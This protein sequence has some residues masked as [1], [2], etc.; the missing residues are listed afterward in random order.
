M[1]VRYRQLSATLVAMN[2]GTGLRR[3]AVAGPAHLR[4]R[5]Q[6]IALLESSAVFNLAAPVLGT[7][8][9]GATS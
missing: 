4:N 5:P 7:A 2:L 1:P 3:T 9:V 6:E 8:W